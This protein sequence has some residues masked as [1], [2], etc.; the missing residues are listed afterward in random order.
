MLEE[1][2]TNRFTQI[3][4]KRLAKLQAASSSSTNTPSPGQT[5][6][7]I[8]PA[9]SVSSSKAT[10]VSAPA[11]PV[12]RTPPARSSPAPVKKPATPVAAA[13]SPIPQ[14]KP[15]GPVHLDLPAWEAETV[16]KV[17]N[18][19]LDVSGGI[20]VSRHEGMLI[21]CGPIE[22]LCR[23]EWVGSCLVETFGSGDGV[24]VTRCV[25]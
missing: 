4:L 8:S 3:R 21:H 23:E 14:K 17:L 16:S 12:V 15:Q 22:R 20:Q 9:P 24:R 1:N 10:P 7:S 18:V 13:P 2:L 5:P 6:P 19:T 11:P 25:A